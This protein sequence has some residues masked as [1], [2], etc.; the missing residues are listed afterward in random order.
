[1]TGHGDDLIGS[2][3]SSLHAQR[4][5]QVIEIK[6]K[7]AFRTANSLTEVVLLPVIPPTFL[8]R[9]AGPCR[10]CVPRVLPLLS[11]D[12]PN[13]DP[14]KSWRTR[15]DSNV[16]PLPSEG[17]IRGLRRF[18]ATIFGL[19]LC[20]MG[21]RFSLTTFALVCYDLRESGSYVVASYQTGSAMTWPSGRGTGTDTQRHGLG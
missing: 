9:G 12:P 19:H 11:S 3:W 2:C 5:L 13:P 16:R 4:P 7:V 8:P 14:L 6:G 10:T 21:L 17:N 18:A 15:H 20:L 1:M